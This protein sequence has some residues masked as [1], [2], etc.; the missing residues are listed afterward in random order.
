MTAKRKADRSLEERLQ[1][2]ED[3]IEIYRLIASHPPSV[4][5]RVPAYTASVWTEDGEFDRG[6]G[7]DSYRGLAQIAPVAARPA[8]VKA[9]EGG[10]CHFA[11][12][13]HI[14][15]DGDTA[16]V[17]SYLQILVLQTQG[18]PVDVPLHGNSRGHRVHRVVANRW[19]LVRTDDGWKIKRRVLR[20]IDG[21]D[22]PRQILRGAFESMDAG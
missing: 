19:E 8:M 10:L 17:I 15:I 12:L 4:D 21:S 11:G 2:V 13:P 22:A 6:E 20:L 1:E 16:V 9:Q 18:E 14:D 3:H 7:L 5:G